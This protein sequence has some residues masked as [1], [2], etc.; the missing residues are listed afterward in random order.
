M[1]CATLLTAYGDSGRSGLVSLMGTSSGNTMPYSSEEHASW[2]R[3]WSFMCRTAS[4][5]LTCAITL[6]VSDSLGAL[7]DVGTNDCAARWKIQSGRTFSSVSRVEVASRRSHS[8]SVI[9]S[10]KCSMF[11]VRLRQ[12]WMP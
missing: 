9:L 12:R 7:H 4:K 6:V 11:S 1:S 3:H 10:A 8:S 5:M 2:M